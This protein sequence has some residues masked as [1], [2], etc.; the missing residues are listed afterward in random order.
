M[1]SGQPVTPAERLAALLDL[2]V[3]YARWRGER[4]AA[5]QASQPKESDD[6]PTS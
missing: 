5:Q 4:V 6:A 2:L 3:E 1:P